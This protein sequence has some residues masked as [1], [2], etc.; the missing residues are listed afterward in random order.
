MTKWVLA[1]NKITTQ[2]NHYYKY[3]LYYITLLQLIVVV[4]NWNLSWQY[5]SFIFISFLVVLDVMELTVKLSIR[6]QQMD[7]I[8]DLTLLRSSWL[9]SKVLF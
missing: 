6:R 9:L 4:D 3:G 7:E 5:Q 2:Y 8:K 1:S